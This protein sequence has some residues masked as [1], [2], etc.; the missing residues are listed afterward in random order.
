MAI[1]DWYS[2]YVLDWELSI[3]MEAD[4]CIETLAG[5]LA[6]SHCDIFNTDQG[7]QFTS[8]EFTGLLKKHTI[9]ISMDGKGR[10]LDNIFVERLWRSVKYES[11]YIHDWETVK[12]AR[13]GLKEYFYFYNNERPHKGVNKKTPYTAHFETE[14]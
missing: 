11:V 14:H 9:K 10:A 1:I 3:N 2:R 12:D 13:E 8:N 7:S 6:T 5:V 4:F